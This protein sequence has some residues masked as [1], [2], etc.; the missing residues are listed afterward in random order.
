MTLSHEDV[1]VRGD[2][3]RIR[4]EEERRVPPAAGLAQ[5]HEELAGRTELEDLM[6]LGRSRIARR[7]CAASPT[8]TR[9]RAVDYPHVVITIDEDAVW[10]DDQSGA[11]MRH[12]RSRR[13]ELED[14][15]ET[16]SRTAVRAAS[17]GDPD[18]HAVLVYRHGAGRSPH[19]SLGHLRPARDRLI[20]IRRVVGRWHR[21]LR[22]RCAGRHTESED[23]LSYAHC[24]PPTGLTSILASRIAAV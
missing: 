16:R 4:L 10:R 6:A 15:I 13:I 18:T 7:R 24:A 22:T 20:R 12:E 1:A 2:K 17:F 11:E 3:Q 19:S 21:R 8:A 9:A 14:R 5:R 23:C